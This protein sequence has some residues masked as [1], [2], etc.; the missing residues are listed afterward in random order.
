MVQC[1]PGCVAFLSIPTTPHHSAAHSHYRPRPPQHNGLYTTNYT[2]LT[3]GPI[4]G[5]GIASDL[6]AQLAMPAL[7]GWGNRELAEGGLVV[8]GAGVT[9]GLRC[10]PPSQPTRLLYGAPLA[11]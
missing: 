11:G 3:A 7:Y 8:W 4:N 5:Y 10:L 1:R 6:L 2:T 9:G